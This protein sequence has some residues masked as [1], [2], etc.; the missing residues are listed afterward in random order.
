MR[1]R[2]RACLIAIPVCT[3]LAFVLPVRSDHD[4]IDPVSGSMKFRTSLL[5]IPVKTRIEQSELERWIVAH[6]GAHVSQ[7]RSLS[8]VASTISGQVIA[9]GCNLSPA[10]HQFHVRDLNT[11]FVRNA[12]D[13]EI[14]EFVRVMR[15]GTRDEQAQ[16]VD[17][18]SKILDRRD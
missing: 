11:R 5:F 15:H 13:A 17:E 18:A 7:W 4:W 8:D 14:A 3:I 6:E 2:T 16:A 10:I 1:P 9:R 12:T